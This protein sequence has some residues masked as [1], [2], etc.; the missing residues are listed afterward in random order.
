MPSIDSLVSPLRD[1]YRRATSSSGSPTAIPA[2]TTST[3]TRRSP[4][5]V[6]A[7]YDDALAQL[8]NPSIALAPILARLDPK[9]AKLDELQ[10]RLRGPY[11]VAGQTV[12]SG[13]Q[14]RMV[15]GYNQS[16]VSA[17]SDDGRLLATIAAKAGLGSELSSLQSGRGDPKA[18][19]ALTQ[20]LIDAGQLSGASG[21]S[22][23]ARIHDLQ[24]RFGIG[25][26][27]AGYVRQALVMLHGDVAKLGVKSAGFESF[28]G[29]SSNP[30]FAKVAPEAARAGDVMVLAGDGSSR[31][32]GHNLVVRSCASVAPGSP[33]LAR[34]KGAAEFVDGRD[35]VSMFEVDSSFGAGNGEPTGG[36][37]RD[38]LLYDKSTGA[39]CT[40][41]DVEPRTAERG[42]VP[43]SEVRLTGI[44]RAKVSP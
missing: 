5:E 44:F 28:T 10:A 29:L 14:F 8:P 11:T 41:R 27:C 17:T 18:L 20:S 33:S 36:V 38:A 19:V 3:P 26:D 21:R 40:C 43:Y 13:A 23:P 16:R 9:G 6:D 2:A 22:I 35:S 1:L 24:W 31:N 4:A 39:W 42:A 32:P 7:S 25:L 12:E 34:W 30:H 37:R 15:G